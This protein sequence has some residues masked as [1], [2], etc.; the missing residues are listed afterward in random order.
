MWEQDI[1]ILKMLHHKDAEG[2]LF[3]AKAKPNKEKLQRKK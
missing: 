2:I 1:E 3:Y